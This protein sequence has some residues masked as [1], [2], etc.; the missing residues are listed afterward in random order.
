MKKYI[1]IACAA[2][3]AL[4]LSGCIK[5]TFPTET[6]LSTQIGQSSSAIEGMVNSIYT[7]MVGYY[8]DDGGVETISYGANVLQLEHSTTLMSCVGAGGYNT[9]GAW[10]QGG[11]N[12]SG[13]GKYPSYIYYGYIKTVNDVIGVVDPETATPEM[14]AYLGIA[15]AYRALYYMDF[16]TVMEY[17]EP[18]DTR[19]SSLYAAPKSKLDNLGVPIVT[20]KTS[21]TD[22]SNN[23]RATVDE[24]YDLILSDLANAELYLADYARKDKVEP[25]LAVV[26]GLYARAYANL[27][28]RTERAAKYTAKA[29]YWQ[30]VANYAELAISTSGCSPLTKD[31]WL[32]PAK[33]FNDRN[34]Q[35]SWM[36]ATHIDPNNT[37]A[38]LGE[39]HGSSFN[40]AMIMGTETN[41]SVYGW[42]VGRG[43]DRAAYERL[44]DNDWRKKSWLSPEFFYK[45]ANQKGDEYLVEKDASGNFINNKW[46]LKGN[47]N[48]DKEEEWSTDQDTDYMLNSNAAWIRSRLIPSN[49]FVAWPYLYVNIKFRP[50]GGVYDNQSVGGATDFPIMRVE[51]MYFLKAEAELNTSGPGAAKAT[52]EE[53][54]KTRNSSYVC[55]ASSKKDVYEELIFQK[56]IEF[57]G[58][59]INY[60]DAKRLELGIHRWYEGTSVSRSNYAIDMNRINVG[61]T[62]QFN[63]AELNGN[64]AVYDFDNP[65]TTYT[66][67]TTALRT[68]AELASFYGAPIDLS[69]H[70]FFDSE[71]FE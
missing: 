28:S 55:A 5:E 10:T 52:L 54:V 25:N 13:R 3:A 23:P 71:K 21:A 31:Q 45:S 43:L 16:V 35:N 19:Y 14:L 61:W 18:L 47:N 59:G 70:K 50:A 41:F 9:M 33:G 17:K 60:F 7:N 37:E 51:E 69:Q 36:L 63:T 2:C 20:D 53:I 30:K 66:T 1:V 12:A 68:N 22:A 15:Y 39:A 40:Y 11:I 38:T 8:N 48:S 34:S 32:D 26:Y 57:W 24:V 49:G 67:Y 62:P 58:E 27:A 64:S 44:S 29:E 46:S 56:G 6:V 42:R 4:C 65:Y